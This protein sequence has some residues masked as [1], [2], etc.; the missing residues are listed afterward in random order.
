MTGGFPPWDTRGCPGSSMTL[1]QETLWVSTS[2][3]VS[4]PSRLFLGTSHHCRRSTSI[5]RLFL[6]RR[7]R[8]LSGPP[9]P[10]SP[11]LTQ[12]GR[13]SLPAHS[14]CRATTRASCPL[15]QLSARGGHQPTVSARA[16]TRHPVLT[17]SRHAPPFITTAPAPNV[18][19]KDAAPKTTPA[20]AAVPPQISTPTTLSV[21]QPAMSQH[22]PAENTKQAHAP[23][24]Y[25]HHHHQPANPNP[26]P[27]PAPKPNPQPQPR[28]Q[29]PSLKQTSATTNPTP[30]NKKPSSSTTA[31][32]ST[33]PGQRSV[34]PTWR[35]GPLSPAV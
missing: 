9:R 23:R 4:L 3:N 13:H 19:V 21:P 30:S 1:G 31:S 11:P 22:H 15:R 2:T 7:F 12:A 32:T 28:H 10:F 5:T 8:L 6:R 27:K 17:R 20:S 14:R 35:A 18:T 34:A 26:P 24:H 29:K 16:A 33:C 25:H